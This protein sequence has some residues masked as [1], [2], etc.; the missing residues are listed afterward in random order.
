[1]DAVVQRLH[2]HPIPYQPKRA[3]PSVPQSNREHTPKA[4]NAI[5]PPALERME[6]HFRIRMVRLPGVPAQP[7][8]LYSDLRMVVDLA[9]ERDPEAAVPIG[10]RLARGCRQI[11]NC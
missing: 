6:N 1:M 10:H 3:L 9:V 4:R 2:S 8:E 5:N 11:D 7:L